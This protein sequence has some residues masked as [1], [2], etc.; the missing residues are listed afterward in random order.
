MLYN[1][2]GIIHI[3]RLEQTIEVVDLIHSRVRA[4]KPA[5][6]NIDGIVVSN[7]FQKAS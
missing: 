4:L 1:V 2:G 3:R 6:S 5:L 7:F